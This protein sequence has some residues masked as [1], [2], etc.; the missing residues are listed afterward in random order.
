MPDSPPP[1]DSLTL[2]GIGG[3]FNGEVYVLLPGQSA[4]V[5][6]SSLATFSVT[7]CRN[8]R[9]LEAG[10]HIDSLLSRMSPE[11][12]RFVYVG[13]GRL[14]IENL[15]GLHAKAG[16]RP[17]ERRTEVDLGQGR[18]VVEF[19]YGE[20]LVA[21]TPSSPPE[22]VELAPP[23]DGAA[24][25][26]GVFMALLAASGPPADRPE[27]EPEPPL[28]L[29]PPPGETPLPPTERPDGE[30]SDG[31][32]AAGPD[33]RTARRTQ[34][35]RSFFRPSPAVLL[36]V[37]F[38]LVVILGLFSYM[39]ILRT[40]ER[41]R[42]TEVKVKAPETAI[43]VPET[44]PPDPS[45]DEAAAIAEQTGQEPALPTFKESETG[46]PVAEEDTGP[47]ADVEPGAPGE[48]L[49][50]LVGIGPGGAGAPGGRS[51]TGPVT[52]KRG[53]GAVA[54]TVDRGLGWLLRH[55]IEDGS[56]R[57]AASL[58]CGRCSGPGKRD[59]PAAVTGLSLLAFVGAGHTHRAGDHRTEVKNAARFLVGRQR[60][61]GASHPKDVSGDEREMYGNAMATLALSELFAATG[62]QYLKA[63]VE[64]GVR[65]IERA[66]APYAG[67]RYRPHER[68]SDTSVT[69]WQMLALISAGRA[70]VRVNPATFVGARRWLSS[71]TEP[72]TFRVGYNRRGRGSVGITATAL[73]LRLILRDRRSE[74]EVSGG[75]D[76]LKANPPVW[77][78]AADPTSVGNPPD[79]CYWYFGTLATR[80]LGDS[81]GRAWS[82]AM[83][84]L[85]LSRQSRSGHEDG[86]WPP[87]GRWSRIGGRPFTT[88]MCILMLE[89]LEDYEGVFR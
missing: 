40:R 58:A 67:W 29:A 53:G 28:A 46:S 74:P 3:L 71:M 64:R 57:G 61:D 79:V 19:G 2:E 11:H 20:R 5:G 89:M 45:S 43:T 60:D 39:T 27:P 49:S 44:P 23:P 72:S 59:Y 26:E 9:R 88:A 85:L 12:L 69:V 65:Y 66:Q 36:S 38:H 78:A 31:A 87:P 86:S 56:W 80:R 30:P 21:S 68:D 13:G 75:I 82:R 22:L 47:P 34:S 54:A 16:R 70:G 50:G 84:S 83:E 81:D 6:S 8:Y 77:P 18:V 37:L 51:G 24:E 42:L 4:S 17:F 52:R 15:V 63:P 32:A 33:S 25:V 14:I 7:A 10:P 76:L 73:A 62:S 55:Q 41:A 35:G 48:G 1:E